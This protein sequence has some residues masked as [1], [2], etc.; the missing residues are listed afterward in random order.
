MLGVRYKDHTKVKCGIQVQALTY[1]PPL[2]CGLL[3]T[4]ITS[5]WHCTPLKLLLS[6]SVQAIIS[7]NYLT[8]LGFSQSL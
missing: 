8:Y 4:S 5:I 7:P 3:A 2:D 6:V 1:A